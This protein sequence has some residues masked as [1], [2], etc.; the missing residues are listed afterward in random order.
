MKKRILVVED[1]AT[2]ARV[3]RDNLTFDGFDVQCVSEGSAALQI[4]R[5]FTPDLVGYVSYAQG[6]EE[7]E[8][9]PA[10]TTNQN[11]HMPPGVSKQKEIGLR[12]L[13]SGGMLLSGALFDIERP[14]AY[15]NSANTFVA[16]GRQRYRGLELS[17]QGQL[18]RQLA[19]QLSAQTLDAE[20]R[21]INAQYNGKMPENT[22][23][24]T[25]SA[26]LSY[27]IAAV[28]GLSVNGGAYYTGKRPIDDLNQGFI[29][30]YTILAA[31][32]RYVTQL[33]GK[34]TLWQ[35]NIDNLGDKRYWSAAGTRLAVGVPRTIKATVK[36]DL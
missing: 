24:H 4:V 25:A 28:P 7:G 19:W 26:F 1:D 2:L 27:D 22:A 17:A 30:G 14:G 20:F 12:W 18:T 11:A 29:D 36:V 10:G 8:I 16:D 35:L 9:A 5:E 6:V 13:T 15:T 32:A 34:R 3:L 31:G 21:D 23:K 33:F